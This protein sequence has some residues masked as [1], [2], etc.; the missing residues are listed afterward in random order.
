ML[1]AAIA[2]ALVA[3]TAAPA[4]GQAA[5]WGEHE[6][7]DGTGVL[8]RHYFENRT[9]FPS[10]H[11]LRNSTHSGSI[12]HLF[13]ATSP[14]SAHFWENGL[15]PGSRHFW[16]NGVA[17]GSR[18]YWE[19]GRGCLS[20]YG[21]LTAT[22]CTSGEVVILQILCVAWVIDISPCRVVNAQLD[23]WVA[24]SG[25]TNSGYFA[26]VLARMRQSDR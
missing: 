25:F 1:A 19:N 20:R 26:D 17:P 21:W 8:S 4:S 3:Q 12:H 22:T 16:E 5:R 13:N 9:G 23:D 11:Y 18:H 15:L 2:L 7:G 6:W 14:G 10:A 24:A